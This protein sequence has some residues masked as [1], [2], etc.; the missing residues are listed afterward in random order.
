MKD[1]LT[2]LFV[3]QAITHVQIPIEH[4]IL[5]STHLLQG[6]AMGQRGC[7]YEAT[8]LRRGS[9]FLYS[10]ELDWLSFEGSCSTLA[11]Y[12]TFGRKEQGKFFRFPRDRLVDRIIGLLHFETAHY[13]HET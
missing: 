7:A 5:G 4:E 11:S 10:S 9:Y 1:V 6:V 12:V 8:G 2:Q 13:H 3:A